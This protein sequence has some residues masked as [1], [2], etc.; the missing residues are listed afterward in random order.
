MN[1][2]NER[3]IIHMNEAKELFLRFHHPNEGCGA[4]RFVQRCSVLYAPVFL[5]IKSAGRD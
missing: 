2:R 5:R 1:Y 4:E 3:R